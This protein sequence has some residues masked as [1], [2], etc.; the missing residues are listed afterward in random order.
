MQDELKSPN[1]VI[2]SR[3]GLRGLNH[4][5]KLFGYKPG[6]LR[7]PLKSVNAEDAK[8]IDDVYQKFI[9]KKI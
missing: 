5:M 4:A 2:T 3:F 1:E 9:N 8:I 6:V 7:S